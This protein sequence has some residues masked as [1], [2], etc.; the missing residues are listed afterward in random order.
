MMIF[1]YILQVE[2]GC[3]CTAFRAGDDEQAQRV[4]P[5]LGIGR[6]HVCF[7]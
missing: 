7:V 5:Q 1:L 4:Q 2:A 6:A 3:L